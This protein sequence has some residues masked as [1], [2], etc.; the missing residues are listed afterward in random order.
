MKTQKYRSN[1]IAAALIAAVVT[2]V[3]TGSLV[4]SLNPANLVRREAS[5]PGNPVVALDR[6]GER[7]IATE[8]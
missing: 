2:T 5:A 3:I 8:G 4:E 7:R 1:S 6:R